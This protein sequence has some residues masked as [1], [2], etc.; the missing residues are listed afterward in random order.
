MAQRITI[1]PITRLE[2]HGKIQIFLD[3]SGNVTNVRTRLTL[4]GESKER[5]FDNAIELSRSRY[6]SAATRPLRFYREYVGSADETAI[7]K[8]RRRWHVDY[9]GMRFYVNFDRLTEPEED[10]YYLELKSRT[11]SPHDAERKVAAI[12]EMLDRLGVKSEALIKEEYV[13]FKGVV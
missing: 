12:S 4:T 10:G 3:D 7:V 13:S 5:V 1:D 9:M 2:G 6:I 11:W 8:E